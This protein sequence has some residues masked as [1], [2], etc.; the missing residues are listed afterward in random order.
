MFSEYKQFPYFDEMFNAKGEIREHYKHVFQ[1]LSKMSKDE[2]HIKQE[3][4]QAQMM[5]QGVTFTL[6]N[7]EDNSSLERTIPVD[8]I[9]RIISN[10][11]WNGIEKGI[12]QRVKAL[13]H[14]IRDVY[15][16]Q[17]ILRENIIPRKMVLSNPYFLPEMMGV[18]VPANVYI[19][20]AGIDLIRDDSGQ[21]FVLE[22]NLRTPS[23][24]SYVFKNRS[25]MIHLFPELFFEH[26]IRPID[27]SMNTLLSVLRSLSLNN[28]KDPLV[29][30]LTPGSYNSAY[31]EHTFLAQQ[32]G[33]DLVEG[34][35]LK[36]M[37]NKVYM[38]TMKGL[39]QVDIVYRR[40]DDDFLD[41]LAFR[42]DSLLGVP[43]IMN[44]YRAGNVAIANA[45]GTGV[46]DDKAIYTYV[47][48]MIRF[49][50]NE[51]PILNNIPTYILS[52]KKDLEYVLSNLSEMVV[53]ETSLSGGYGMLI[54][55]HATDKE[56][57]QF[58]ERIILSPEK[59]I[60]QPTINLSCAPSLVDGKIAGRHVD[61]RPFVFMG[62]DGIDVTPG[63]LTR[64]ALKEG[65]LVVNSSQGGGSKDTWVL[66]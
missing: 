1:Q 47:P 29:V 23:G 8:I 38:K 34:K 33:I 30:L 55:P 31:F 12:M 61:L 43:G 36:V 11:E 63:G 14:F 56:L 32:M 22:D 64:V 18:E 16:E 21:Y 48:E 41:P 52:R 27:E 40:V 50:L 62:R 2:L 3:S 37:D 26:K 49:Y 53:K 42:P 59:Y 7:G 51:E 13:N 44:A 54:G 5:R 20:L 10:S 66:Y 65:S 17:A 39:R 57:N 45:P 24:L 28:Q 58:K 19:P 4:M 9:P 60:A 6:Y 35:D 46:A 25:S 15:H